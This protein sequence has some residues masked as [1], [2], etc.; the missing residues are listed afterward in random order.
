MS[1]Q[2]TVLG[3]ALGPYARILRSGS[4]PVRVVDVHTAD[5]ARAVLAG[6]PVDC[7]VVNAVDTTVTAEGV[8]ATADSTGSI[9]SD[10]VPDGAG[11]DAADY[12][13]R[14]ALV[15]G[16]DARSLVE[17]VGTVAGDAGVPTV[18]LSTD[19]VPDRDL[20]DGVFGSTVDPG[21]VSDGE[22]REKS[23]E[24]ATGGSPEAAT[25]G[26]P[27]AATAFRTRV[28]EI[29]GLG[30]D[31]PS[32]EVSDR[33][34]GAVSN[35]TKDRSGADADR[36]AGSTDSSDAVTGRTG[37]PADGDVDSPVDLHEDVL[38]WRGVGNADGSSDILD[39]TFDG[40]LDEQDGTPGLGGDGVYSPS[41]SPAAGRTIGRDSSDEAEE[42]DAAE[43]LARTLERLD[44]AVQRSP[45]A[46]IDDRVS[47]LLE[48]GMDRFDA[49]IGAVCRVDD[50]AGTVSFEWVSGASTASD[51]DAG[52]TLDLGTGE[53]LLAGS[54][55]NDPGSESDLSPSVAAEPIVAVGSEDGL[56]D[57]PLHEELDAQRY[58]GIPL[59]MEGPEQ[60]T[61]LFA[62][63][64]GG[65][66][67]LSRTDRTVGR[68]FG[69]WA[70]TAL[71]RSRR[72]R[73]LAGLNRLGQRLME[74]TE[75]AAIGKETVETAAE[76]MD[77]PSTAVLTFDSAATELRTEAR[78]GAL[79][80]LPP[81]TLEAESGPVWDAFVQGDETA[82]RIETLDGA[83]EILAVRLSRHGVFLAAAR[84]DDTF[85]DATVEFVE[86]V[87]STVASAFER[88]AGER[89]LR[90]RER[91][92]ERRN[93][94]LERLDEINDVIRNIDQALVAATTRTEIEEAV[95]RHLATTG[96]YDLA[97]VGTT[98]TLSGEVEITTSA[99]ENDDYID[100]IAIT[101]DDEPTGR[102]PAGRALSTL[103]PQVVEDTVAAREFEPW[104]REAID[105]GYRSVIALPLVYEGTR[106]GVLVVYDDEP[107]AFTDLARDV[108]TELSATVAHAINAVETKRGLE[109]GS[110]T[111]LSFE[112]DDHAL[113]SFV[114]ALDCEVSLQGTVVAAD[115]T[116]RGYYTVHGAEAADVLDRRR[117][118][119][120]T[121]VR[122]SSEYVVDGVDACLVE[123]DLDEESFCA[124]VVD[125]GGIVESL[126]VTPDGATATVTIP[127]TASVRE[128]VA[129]VE[130]WVP[131]ARLTAKRD[132]ERSFRNS[133]DF[134][135]EVVAALTDRQR[136]VLE[137]AYLSGYF[138]APRD[139]TASQIA[140]SLDITQPTFT[141]H[142]RTA[143]RKLLELLL[144]RG[145]RPTTAD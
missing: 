73:R 128:F 127:S 63:L 89:E 37:D 70:W 11:T 68:V 53:S 98:D 121:N 15:S 94:T 69:R 111:E 6:T 62:S 40:A 2:P 103:E 84:G 100:A 41:V 27:E 5:E 20:P 131:G 141:T 24:A 67:P 92:L 125:H 61:L 114:A 118:F 43:R 85:G 74:F 10:S 57:A 25:G 78:T 135:A 145:R 99:G 64:E 132:R 112:T 45:A 144:E 36:H 93:E 76:C 119:P 123:V 22:R 143:Q 129:S 86:A 71:E 56:A 4:N 122:V 47:A 42:R 110:V 90:E 102:G 13:G 81:S 113:T 33:T 60:W 65:D 48:V 72:E 58:V 28:R 133:D 39:A 108:L 49:E 83:G 95:C 134:W 35:H 18:L 107:N 3:V 9:P 75:P 12:P 7:A 31:G 1:S 120:G 140:D 23:P 51:V 139:L 91:E 77:L 34:R 30:R 16:L 50:T 21:M 54:R 59:P 80:E 136:E 117:S 106:Y 104:R 66:T 105:R 79:A 26:S 17:I 142:L 101:V 87:G 116:Y 14:D 38:P 126:R 130:R 138:N 55:A 124:R 32:D 46:E 97:W 137:T 88:A 109:S 82:T 29:A 96:P 115:G 8:A 19:E 44:D 52:R